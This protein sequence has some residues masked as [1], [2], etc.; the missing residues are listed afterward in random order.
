MEAEGKPEA[1]TSPAEQKLPRNDKS[2][3]T[4]APPTI[5]TVDNKATD[6]EVQQQRDEEEEP[7]SSSKGPNDYVSQGRTPK[8]ANTVK[9]SSDPANEPKLNLFN[10][11]PP[12][13]DAAVYA[14]S[15][16]AHAGAFQPR[17]HYAPGMQQGSPNGNNNRFFASYNPAAPRFAAPYDYPR[18]T[19]LSATSLQSG[20]ANVSSKISGQRVSAAATYLGS[21][22]SF[23]PTR[24]SNANASRIDRSWEPKQHG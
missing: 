19:K 16:L 18:Y 17:D 8:H 12:L 10:A 14:S 5:I 3:A 4:P 11:Q 7:A 9:N 1:N 22:A 20:T 24:K 15:G 6:Q 21:P 23:I 2:S 13:R